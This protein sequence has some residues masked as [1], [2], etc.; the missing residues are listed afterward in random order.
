MKKIAVITTG[1]WDYSHLFWIMKEI[2][3]REDIYEGNGNM[4]LN[5]ICPLNHYNWDNIVDEFR[6]IYPICPINSIDDYGEFY[7]DCLKL[8]QK[9]YM[10]PDMVM[11]LGDTWH[12]HAAATAALLLNIPIA[13]IHGGE[14]TTGAFDNELRNSITQMATYHFTAT[15]EYAQNVS[16]MINEC[17]ASKYY[18]HYQCESAAKYVYTVGSPGL[19]WVTHVKLLS[20]QELQHHVLIDLNQPFVVACMHPTTKELSEIG[21]QSDEFMKSLEQCEEQVLIIGSNIDPGNDIIHERVWRKSHSGKSIIK[22]DN[23]DHLTYLS[24]LQYAEMMVGNSSSGIIESASFNLPVVN[25]GT[26]QQGRIKPSNVFDCGYSTEEILNCIE[27]ARQYN[28][29]QESRSYWCESTGIKNPYGDGHSAEKI[30][31]VLEGR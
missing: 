31:K 7:K 19:D 20:R 26:R 10:K 4:E 18:G 21:Y 13:H 14:E 5:V 1:R 22:I 8:L 23:L 3:S 30:V 2:Q 17:Y 27:Q 25:V 9:S 12:I 11:V 6:Y 16:R 28:E 29:G 24:L 15:K